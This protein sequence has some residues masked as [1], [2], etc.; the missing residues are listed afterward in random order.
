MSRVVIPLDL[1][2]I[3]SDFHEETEHNFDM[4]MEGAANILRVTEDDLRYEFSLHKNEQFSYAY[5][6]DVL[7]Y[8]ESL[9]RD[10]DEKYSDLS[11]ALSAHMRYS[12]E[13]GLDTLVDTVGV[14]L[15]I[16]FGETNHRSY[17]CMYI[18]ERTDE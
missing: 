7:N 16:Y 13:D 15:T 11:F 9:V 18:F 1:G 12:L 8:L 17:K 2:M 3:D 10:A 5:A 6:I 14:T 4:L